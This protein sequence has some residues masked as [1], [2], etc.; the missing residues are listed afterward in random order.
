MS[1]VIWWAYRGLCTESQPYHHQIQIIRIDV[2]KPYGQWPRYEYIQFSMSKAIHDLIHKLSLEDEWIKVLIH[3][4]W[5]DVNGGIEPCHP[6][7]LCCYRLIW[8]NVTLP[9]HAHIKGE[10][11]PVYYGSQYE[12]EC[13]YMCEWECDAV[14]EFHSGFGPLPKKSE[15]IELDEGNSNIFLNGSNELTI[16]PNPVDDLVDIIFKSNLTGSFKISIYDAEG[17]NVYQAET[18]AKSE[19]LNWKIQTKH[20][21]SGIYN[22]NI[23]V[24]GLQAV[25]GRFAVIH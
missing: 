16:I 14:Q 19:E 25:N 9:N 23:L 10:Y 5:T 3:Q 7:Y 22:V 20:F 6:P 15:F 12:N 8:V 4:C 1:L 13:T 2:V 24:D 11:D 17:N 18:H 21:A